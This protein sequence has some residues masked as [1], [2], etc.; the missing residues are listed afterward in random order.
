MRRKKSLSNPIIRHVQEYSSIYSFII[1][2]F[3]M[4][5]VFGAIIVNSLSIDQKEDL[6]YYLNQ[7]FGQIS[8][9]KIAAPTDLFRLSFL[10]NVKFLGLMWVLGISIIGL[11]L[12]L[13]L[14]FIKGIVVGFSVGFLVN[15][16]GWGGFLLSFVTV[17]PQ[18]L[19]IIPMF[20]FIA[21]VAVG[22][23]LKLIRKIFI[24]Q[25]MGVQIIPMLTQYFIVL[26]IA[27]GFISIAAG[28]EA[29]ISPELMKSA[30]SYINR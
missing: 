28:V 19:F 25:S 14:L 23:S 7:F 9:G 8:E 3:L 13:V 5:V 20:I 22:V 18:N 12:I 24:K 6:F 27:V 21:V 11:P 29:Y 15:Q 26:I 10:H 2:L 16:M 1:V 30:M 4:G 17:L